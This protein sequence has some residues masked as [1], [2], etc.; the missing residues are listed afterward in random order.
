MSDV[1]HVMNVM[2]NTLSKFEKETVLSFDEMKVAS[3]YEYDQ[4]EDEVVGPHSYMQV[5]MARGLFVNG[6]SL[7]T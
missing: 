3:A 1:I 2:G 7:C 4:K 6:S 5:I